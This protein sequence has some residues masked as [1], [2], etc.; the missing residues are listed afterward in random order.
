MDP[1]YLDNNATTACDPEVVATMLP[2][3]EQLW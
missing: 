3:V 2:F 1:I